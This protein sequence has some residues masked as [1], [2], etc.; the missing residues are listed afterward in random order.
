MRVCCKKIIDYR[1]TYLSTP[2]PISKGRVSGEDI[3]KP[4]SLIKSK[5]KIK[6]IIS[7]FVLYIMLM[8]NACF[9]RTRFNN[10]NWQMDSLRYYTT[11]FDSILQQQSKDMVL[12]RTDFYTKS[13]ELAEKMEMLNTRLNESETQLTQINEKL[14][15]GKKVSPDSDEISSVGPEARMIYES[16]YLNYVKGSYNE[17]INGFKSYLKIAPDSPLSDNALYWIGE[18]YYS[19][20]KRQD[21]VDTFNELITKYPQSNKK[22][23][24]LYKTG[25]IYEEAKELKTARTYYERVIKEFP[26]APEASLAKERMK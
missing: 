2:L 10:F 12:L 4:T 11:K 8:G 13:E 17:A 19:M 5:M 23:T 14:S 24:V 1:T 7:V 25:I 15:R 3:T 6:G 16:A 20:G 9:N 21:A 26:N 22:P 18:C